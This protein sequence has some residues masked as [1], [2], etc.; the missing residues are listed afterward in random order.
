M[1]KILQ[2]E[3]EILTGEK[4]DTNE[5]YYEKYFKIRDLKSGIKVKRNDGNIR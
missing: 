5:D 1:K 2:L 4:I 3:Q